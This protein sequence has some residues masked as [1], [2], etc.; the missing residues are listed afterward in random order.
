MEKNTKTKSGTIMKLE[1]MSER[2]IND[3]LNTW[4]QIPL[5]DLNGST[6][7]CLLPK[8]AKMIKF[9]RSFACKNT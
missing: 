9:E 5:S 6:F 7:I 4:R 8:I 2:D 3:K 1:R